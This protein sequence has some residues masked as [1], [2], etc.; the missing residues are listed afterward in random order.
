MCTTT[1]TRTTP[2]NVK[3]SE[4]CEKE[5]SAVTPTAVTGATAEEEEETPDAGKTMG[6]AKGGATNLTRIA[7]RTR[8]TREAGGFSLA[9]IAHKV[10]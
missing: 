9:W 8:L 10:T 2:T 1:S 3:N 6:R 7:G 4:P 5:G